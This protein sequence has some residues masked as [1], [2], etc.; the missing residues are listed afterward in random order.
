LP[1][2]QNVFEYIT[3]L[4]LTR[5]PEQDSRSFSPAA[6]GC[7]ILL[8]NKVFKFINYNDYLGQETLNVRT[9]R[10]TTKKPNAKTASA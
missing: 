8:V 5:S 2:L 6:A 3:A 1:F 7:L 4:C 10:L 9:K